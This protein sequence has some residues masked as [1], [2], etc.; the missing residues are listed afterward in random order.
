VKTTRTGKPRPKPARGRSA[1]SSKPTVPNTNGP[2]RLNR[3]LALSGVCTRR[4]ADVLIESGAVQVNG[5]VVVA[6]GHKVSKSDVVNVGGNRIKPE[7]K[8]YVILNKPKGF[9]ATS[10]DPRGRR[11]VMDLI[12]K[13]YREGVFP[14][15]KMER[16]ATGLLL[17]TN[18]TTVADRLGHPRHGV[19][20]I[21]QLSLAERVNGTHLEKMLEGF[22]LDEGFVKVKEV[23]VL[24]E[25]RKQIGLEINS[26][27]SRIARR[28]FEH[29][30]YR[31]T[32]VDRVVLGHLTKKDLPRGHFRELTESELN[33]L[34]MSL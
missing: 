20:Q 11:T 16:E 31:V 5:E 7:T 34:W 9:S 14:V 2:I 10:E 33:V 24:D 22:V 27:R 29:F 12:R 30:G 32:K 28:I 18:D 21:F 17:L 6:M 15:G 1:A 3:Y 4:E 26:N 19:R 23:S 25:D 8:R 13:T